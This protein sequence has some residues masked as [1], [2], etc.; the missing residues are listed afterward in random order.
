[1]LSQNPLIV[2]EGVGELVVDDAGG[3]DVGVDVEL[4]EAE[5]EKMHGPVGPQSTQS[6]FK[7][8]RPIWVC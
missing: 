2:E 8:N 5:L 3:A 7:Q 1:V 4:G 6:F